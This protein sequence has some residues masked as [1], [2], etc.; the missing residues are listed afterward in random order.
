MP[1]TMS[2]SARYQRSLEADRARCLGGSST[3]LGASGDTDG[4]V[5]PN[6]QA[7]S[8]LPKEER[9]IAC[10]LDSRT[11]SAPLSSRQAKKRSIALLLVI[12]PENPALRFAYSQKR[13]VVMRVL[14][15]LYDQQFDLPASA[16]RDPFLI[17]P[18][19][20]LQ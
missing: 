17:E 19:Y 1:I 2:S 10:S 18:G 4:K 13:D 12:R 14:E 11:L 7:L 3:E 15:N 20:A 9:R 16:F 6:W 5:L 8:F